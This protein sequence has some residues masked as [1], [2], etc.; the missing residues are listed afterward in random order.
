VHDLLALGLDVGQLELFAQD[1]GE[2]LELDVDLECVLAFGVAGLPLALT[3]LDVDAFALFALALA[4][5]ASPRAKM[6]AT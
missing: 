1:L 3:L 5:L 6:L 2:L 4:D